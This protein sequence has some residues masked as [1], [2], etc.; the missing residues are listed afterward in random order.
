MSNHFFEFVTATKLYICVNSSFGFKKLLGNRAHES[1]NEIGINANKYCGV[2]YINFKFYGCRKNL[3]PVQCA[4]TSPDRYIFTFFFCSKDEE[5]HIEVNA[6]SEDETHR[7]SEF[8]LQ[9]SKFN[10][11]ATV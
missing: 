8:E 2:L 9:K 7:M 3:L 11:K 1:Y 4:V 10:H 5:E 6:D